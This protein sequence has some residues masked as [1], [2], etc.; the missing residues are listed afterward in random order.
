[1]NELTVRHRSLVVAPLGLTSIKV[2]MLT[3][4]TVAP[5]A[6]AVEA[7]VT[8]PVLELRCSLQVAG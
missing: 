2:V 6:G 4:K 7:D 5:C 1:M 8:L 3:G